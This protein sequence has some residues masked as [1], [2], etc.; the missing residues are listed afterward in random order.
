M[1]YTETQNRLFKFSLLKGCW[2]R[3]SRGLHIHL[4]QHVYIFTWLDN[5]SLNKAFNKS[6]S[7]NFGMC[8]WV[9]CKTDFGAIY[10][11]SS[12][13]L[14]FYSSCNVRLG[15]WVWEDFDSWV[16]HGLKGQCPN[17]VIYRNFNFNS[18]VNLILFYERDFLVCN[19]NS[20]SGILIT[21]MLSCT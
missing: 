7:E 1:V 21:W 15:T 8:V 11:K 12:K 2:S 19:P 14:V 16:S 5:G 4:W 20:T 18:I 6:N 17:S 13:W 3:P 9:D 10:F